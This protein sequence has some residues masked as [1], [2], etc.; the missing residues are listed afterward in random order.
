MVPDRRRRIPWHLASLVGTLDIRRLPADVAQSI[1]AATARALRAMRGVGAELADRAATT[2]AEVLLAMGRDCADGRI[3]LR[4]GSGRL[5]VT[6]DTPSNDTAKRA[7]SADVVHSFDGRPFTTPT[8]R[9]FR[10]TC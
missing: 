1:G 10:V 4:S 3:T 5:T 6:W 8:W 7:A 2:D 9:L